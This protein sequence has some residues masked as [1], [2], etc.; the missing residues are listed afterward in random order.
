MTK[1][2]IFNPTYVNDYTFFLHSAIGDI[3]DSKYL[4]YVLLSLVFISIILIGGYAYFPL[5]S[6]NL[7]L[8]SKPFLFYLSTLILL[9]NF[10]LY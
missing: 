6:G 1:F 9:I 4:K 5:N 3:L 2:Y 10:L 8:P 7:N